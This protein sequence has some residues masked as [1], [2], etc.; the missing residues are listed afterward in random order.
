MHEM[1][2][3]TL[4]IGDIANPPGP[5]FSVDDFIFDQK[6]SALWTLQQHGIAKGSAL[7]LGLAHHHEGD[8]LVITSGWSALLESLGF[9]VNENNIIMITDSKK[10]FED[11]I[12][13]L[14]LAE[15]VLAKEE[16]RLEELEKERAIHRISAETNARQQG[17]SIAETDEIGRSAAASIP[18]EGPQDANRYLASQIEMITE[19]T[20]S[21]Q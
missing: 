6:P 1:P 19:L 18:D 4:E 3:A 11:K 13:K 9:A 15:A 10:I 2:H 14:K 20:E 8:D 12:A 21:Y 7:I 17:K 16:T 5:E